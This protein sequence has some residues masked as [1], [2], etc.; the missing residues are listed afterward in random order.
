ML[1][2]NSIKMLRAET[3]RDSL[4]NGRRGEREKEE[5]GRDEVE[6]DEKKTNE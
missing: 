1:P 3:E 2:S 4:S 5:E 6:K